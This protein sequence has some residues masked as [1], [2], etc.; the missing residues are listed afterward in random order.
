MNR[1]VAFMNGLVGRLLRIVLGLVLIGWGWFLSGSTVG[2]IVGV[3]GLAPLAL[4]LWGR[5]L[6]ELLAAKPKA[7]NS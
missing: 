5:C 2:I 6:L 4:G 3:I 1:L 7:S